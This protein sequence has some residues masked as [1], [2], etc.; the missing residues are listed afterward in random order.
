MIEIALILL[1]Q[2]LSG[3][4]F[5]YLPGECICAL[6]LNEDQ[7]AGNFTGIAGNF[8]VGVDPIVAF[9]HCAHQLGWRFQ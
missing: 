4:L 8:D 2:L 5:W 1:R 3:A 7:V 6:E 9:G